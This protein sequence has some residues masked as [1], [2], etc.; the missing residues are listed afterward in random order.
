MILMLI[1]VIASATMAQQTLEEEK[2]I[3]VTLDFIYV[4]RWLS[5]GF[6]V[7][8]DQGGL[9]QT[10]DLDFYGSGFGLL[11]TYRNSTGDHADFQRFDFRPY[12]KHTVYEDTAYEM[13]YNISGGYEYY[14]KV[15]RHNSPTVWEWI[16]AF[17]WPNI[18]PENFTPAYIAHYE[19]LA[20][21]GSKSF[22]D[23]S[24]PSGW[25]HRFLLFY[26]IP[27]EQLP[28]PIRFSSEVAY[29][30]GLAGL[31][32]DWAYATFGLSSSFPITEN[33]TF[34]PGIYEQVTMDK[35]VNSQKDVTYGR[36]AMR[37]KF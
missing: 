7:Y 24:Y 10:L 4:S 12:F 22:N 37:Y 14:P 8:G 32:Y 20:H 28:N 30:D 11:T 31:T 25:V 21:S 9:F 18:L 36:L 2:K 1:S 16:F 6:P 3:G 33:L 35:S 19:Y 5:K 13:N 26:D 17:N 23:K 34:I 29:Y 15:S 27:M